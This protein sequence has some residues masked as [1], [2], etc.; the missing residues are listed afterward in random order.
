VKPNGRGKSKGLSE[1]LSLGRMS[2]F[3]LVFLFIYGIFYNAIIHSEN[4]TRNAK[5]TSLL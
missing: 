2:S 4:K 3:C 5:M 1:I